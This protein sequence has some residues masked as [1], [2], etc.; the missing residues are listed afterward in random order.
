MKRSLLLLVGLLSSASSSF[1]MLDEAL[2]EGTAGLWTTYSY[3]DLPPTGDDPRTTDGRFQGRSALYNPLRKNPKMP[4]I[5][6]YNPTVAAVPFSAALP[7]AYAPHE[8]ENIYSQNIAGYQKIFSFVIQV[9]PTNDQ[10]PLC[11]RPHYLIH[12]SS[13]A[14]WQPGADINQAVRWTTT[15]GATGNVK[16][17]GENGAG[18]LREQAAVTHGNGAKSSMVLSP[19]NMHLQGIGNRDSNGKDNAVDFYSFIAF[20]DSAT[21]NKTAAVTYHWLLNWNDLETFN[22]KMG[23][24]KTFRQL[25]NGLELVPSFKNMLAE[26]KRYVDF[27]GERAA[28]VPVNVPVKL[29]TDWT[30]T[31]LIKTDKILVKGGDEITVICNFSEVN[32][33]TQVKFIN[34]A[35]NKYYDGGVVVNPGTKTARFTSIVPEGDTHTWL[36]MFNIGW[37]NK[38]HKI[39]FSIQDIKIEN[40]GSFLGSTRIFPICKVNNIPVKLLTDWTKTGLIKTDKLSVKAGDRI[41]VTCQFSEVKEPTNVQFINTAQNKYYEGGVIVTPGMKV[42]QFTS[43]VPEGDTHTWLQFHNVGWNNTPHPI[44]FSIQDVQVNLEDKK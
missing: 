41:T 42:A 5:D 28:R 2:V 11:L 35:Q 30:S 16:P 37:N 38:P 31:G 9:F 21:K 24:A 19:D 8:I 6:T 4:L 1:A 14:L 25:I 33:P 36:Q 29:L 18:E 44:G 26:L 20:E 13:P 15:P 3:K 40:W 32:E 22:E 27:S 43:T 23:E 17:A 39:G 7:K 34:T 10:A 12:P